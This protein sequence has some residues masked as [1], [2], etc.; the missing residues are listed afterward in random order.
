MSDFRI[1]DPKA[2]YTFS[3]YYELSFDAADIFAE[4][5]C[6]FERT[7][8]ALPTYAGPI[9]FTSELRQRLEMAMKVT[10]LASEM[11][12]REALIAPV[13]FAVCGYLEQELKIE[14]R[15]E[16]SNRLNGTLDYFVPSPHNLLVVEAKNAD[17]SKG[18]V[19]LGAELIA[20]DKWTRQNTPVLYGA[21][22]TGDSWQF[23]SYLRAE[24]KVIQD[25]RTYSIPLELEK[26]LS[27][28]IGIIGA[29]GD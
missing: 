2:S 3:K 14:Y 26:L 24:Q 8:L 13:M 1:L 4:L 16:V 23:G 6:A 9:E 17:L 20:L 15:V 22:T 12:R 11:A 27:I 5:D 21:V 10:S 29:A 7:S 25:I 28:L 19:Q 18:F